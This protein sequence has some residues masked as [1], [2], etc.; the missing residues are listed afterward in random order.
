[1]I[2][3]TEEKEEM[4]KRVECLRIKLKTHNKKLEE[5]KSFLVPSNPPHNNGKGASPTE[6]P[7]I[8]EN[9]NV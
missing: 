7:T 6:A 5:I 1:M 3:T 9:R 2:L 8:K 4:F